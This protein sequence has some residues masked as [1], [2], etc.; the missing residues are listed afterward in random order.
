VF[1][2]EIL[3]NAFIKGDGEFAI[4][5]SNRHNNAATGNIRRLKPD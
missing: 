4:R 5:I 1:I 3:N 2:D